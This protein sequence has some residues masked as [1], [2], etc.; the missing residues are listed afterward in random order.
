[1]ILRRSGCF[2]CTGIDGYFSELATKLFTRGGSKLQA[3]SLE[4]L[5]F[6]KKGK[7]LRTKYL[8]I[9]HC[10]NNYVWFERIFRSVTSVSVWCC[11]QQNNLTKFKPINREICSPV[12]SIMS[13]LWTNF[14]PIR[15]W[16]SLC[17]SILHI[18]RSL[19]TY[20]INRRCIAVFGVSPSDCVFILLHLEG[21]IPNKTEPKK[22]LWKLGFLKLYAT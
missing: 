22:L 14:V 19:A 8:I 13:V 18:Y 6:R 4:F 12:L 21:L 2:D 15:R 9:S 16:M 17:T 3:V 7:L 5:H 20:T 10:Q 11:T 1:M